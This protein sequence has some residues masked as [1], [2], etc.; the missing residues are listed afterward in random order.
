MKK[1][2]GFTLIELM[3]VIAIIGILIGLLLPAVQR[4][5]ESARRATCKSNLRQI[6][7]AIHMYADDADEMFPN[8]ADVGNAD[9]KAHTANAPD[10]GHPLIGTESLHLLVP[11]Y[12]DN[13]KI[14]KC[15]SGD[16]K[17]TEMKEG[18]TVT[19]DS[20]SYW[21]DPRHR[22]TRPGSVVILG[23]KRMNAT[24]QSTKSHGGAGGNFCFTDA[25][26]E[27]KRSPSGT[28]KLVLE[29]ETDINGVWEPGTALYEHDTCLVN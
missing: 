14:F 5:R 8:A 24:T 20:S 27:W 2:R 3:V 28:A 18:A 16:A 11:Q 12:V 17:W 22:A 13:P 10:T 23:D 1:R 9:A 25:H 26:V 21:Y 29:K 7:L 6:G 19:A 15:P 4:V